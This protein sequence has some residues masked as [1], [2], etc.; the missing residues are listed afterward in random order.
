MKTATAGIALLAAVM[1]CG[2]TPGIGQADL[3]VEPVLG[4]AGIQAVTPESPHAKPQPA[5]RIA[6]QAVVYDNTGSPLNFALSSSDLL[7]RWGDE[8]LVTSPGLLAAQTLGIFNSGSSVGF[9]GIVRIRVEFYEAAT[10]AFLGDYYVNADF[11]SGL[12]PGY[13][14]LLSVTDLASL[15]IWIPVTDVVVIQSVS[16][17]T[18]GATRLGIVSLD[19]PTV[20]SSPDAMFIQASTVNGGVPGFYTVPSGPAN[21]AYQLTLVTE[22]VGVEPATWGGVKN[23]YR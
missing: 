5:N 12:P 13:Y 4:F 9:L 3:T 1:F 15:N 18:G 21:P 2:L 7:A 22:T 20:G 23:L 16:E 6:V 14:S 19:P 17:F 8:L 11:G 10:N